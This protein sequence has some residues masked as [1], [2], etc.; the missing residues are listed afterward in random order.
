LN[1]KFQLRALLL[2]LLTCYVGFFYRLGGYGLI[3]PDEGRTAVIAKKI[4]RTGN[5]LT[6]THEGAPYYD[7]PAPYFW[8]VAVGFKLFGLNDCRRRR[9]TAERVRSYGRTGQRKAHQK[10][11]L[12]P[13]GSGIYIWKRIPREAAVIANF[14]YQP[15]NGAAAGPSG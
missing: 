2:L 11:E 13:F 8:L 14:P 10:N 5:W 12:D 4:L 15:A 3:D 7:K 9:S 6:L 1:S